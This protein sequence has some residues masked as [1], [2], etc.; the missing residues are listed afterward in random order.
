MEF[1]VIKDKSKLVGTA[2]FEFL[3][4]KYSGTCWNDSSIYLNEESMSIVEGIFE[5]YIDGYDHYSFSEMNNEAFQLIVNALKD[6]IL[7]I[8]N[9]KEINGS[10]F[11]QEYYK[12]LNENIKDD[13][14]AVNEFITV[15]IDWI[16]E[17]SQ[18]E[19]TISI[20]GI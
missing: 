16:K 11:N 15:L 7:E 20:L 6:L 18:K 1:Q 3:P 19:E 8:E 12:L 5:M 17:T 9:D 10:V 4:G 14:Q 13:K 2:Y